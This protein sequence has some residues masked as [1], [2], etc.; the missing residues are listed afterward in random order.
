MLRRGRQA[1]RQQGVFYYSDLWKFL[2]SGLPEGA[3]RF[4]HAVR[5][6]RGC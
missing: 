3:V 4:G 1:T 6:R 5:R 2:Y